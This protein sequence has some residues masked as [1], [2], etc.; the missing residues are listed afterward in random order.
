[1]AKGYVSFDSQEGSS[2]EQDEDGFEQEESGFVRKGYNSIEC[3][4][5]H[6]PAPEWR[7]EAPG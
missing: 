7:P 5:L 3:G 2:G 6:L 1:M 4:I